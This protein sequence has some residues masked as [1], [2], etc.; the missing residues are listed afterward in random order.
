MR[1]K[2]IIWDWN[3]TVVNDSWLSFEILESFLDRLGLKKITL[4]DYRD[5]FSFPVIDFYRKLGFDIS[6]DRF[7]R[8]G[9]D[10]IKR[11]RAKERECKLNP[12]ALEL[13]E[14]IGSLGVGQS[15]LSA[16]QKDCLKD[17]VK[18]FG[19]EKYMSNIVGLDDV[20]ANTKLET[21]KAFISSLGVD[22]SEIL[23]IGDTDHDF[24]V[25]S[26]CKTD[27][28][29]IALGHQSFSRL[30]KTS[31]RVFESFEDMSKALFG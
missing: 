22:P 21:G 23:I 17:A 9:E 5:N 2:H 30:S 13:M 16:Y 20:K 8:L 29:L 24:A 26:S 6:K 11:F 7:D 10:F 4:Q 27:C 25:A 3:G 18:F 28:F 15:V 14:K 1:Y 19:A 12:G 31:A